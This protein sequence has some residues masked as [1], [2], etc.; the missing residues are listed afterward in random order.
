M[1]DTT[2]SATRLAQVRNRIVAAAEAAGRKP[3]DVRLIA[4]SKT[5]EA[6]DIV[7]VIEAGQRRFG[8]NRV[9]EAMRKWPDLR[10]RYGDLE[11][12]LIGPLQTN[13]AAD[14]VSFFDAIQSVDRP[15]L[16]EILAREMAKQGR[17]PYLYIQA[18]TGDES[19]KAGISIAE[20][21]AF[22]RSCVEKLKLPVIGLMCIPPVGT[23]PKPHFHL[24]AEIAKRNGLSRLSMGMSGDYEAAIACG[25]TDVRVGSAIFGTR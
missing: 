20:A 23:D 13:K 15:K 6:P 11:L 3:D 14:A 25:A 17:R 22:I 10:S 21:D 7:P 24:L 1:P 2:S 12:H 9:Q 18:N 19:Q 4:V 16:A 8:E 5:F